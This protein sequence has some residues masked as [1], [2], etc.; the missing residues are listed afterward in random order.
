[1]SVWTIVVG[2]VLGILFFIYKEYGAIRIKI[3]RKQTGDKMSEAGDGNKGL[4]DKLLRSAAL[5]RGLAEKAAARRGE[6]IDWASVEPL[7]DL[8]R[9]AN[10]EVSELITQ[11][12]T[13]QTRHKEVG[14]TLTEAEIV[15][16][17]DQTHFRICSSYRV[18]LRN[19]GNGARCLYGAQEIDSYEPPLGSMKEYRY[20]AAVGPDLIQIDGEEPVPRESLFTLMTQDSNGGT[21]FWLTSRPDADDEYPLAYR[22]GDTLFCKVANFTEWLRILVMNESEVIRVLDKDDKCGLG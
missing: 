2:I 13:R 1:M 14:N 8:S 11:L 12:K 18:F 22:M 9:L 19:F 4:R 7:K 16:F 20:R 5:Q 17:E 21:W 15:E 6:K 10:A 3:S